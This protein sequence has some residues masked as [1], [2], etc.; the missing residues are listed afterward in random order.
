MKTTGGDSR[1]RRYL[2]IRN[3]LTTLDIIL[4][5]LI[6]FSA[7]FIVNFQFGRA[8]LAFGYGMLTVTL[9]LKLLQKW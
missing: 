6:I 5:I 9:I 7:R 8:A 4:A 2:I 3:T 1:E